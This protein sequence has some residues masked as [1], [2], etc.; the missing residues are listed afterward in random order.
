MLTRRLL[1]AGT[2]PSPVIMAMV[3]CAFPSICA[4]IVTTRRSRAGRSLST[5]T[6]L[7]RSSPTTKSAKLHKVVN[8]ALLKDP[9]LARLGSSPRSAYRAVTVGEQTYWCFTMTARLPGLG[10]VRPATSIGEA[11]RQ[12]AQALIEGEILYAHEQLQ[13]GSAS[14][15]SLRGCLPARAGSHMTA[16]PSFTKTQQSS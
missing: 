4:S 11:G 12:Q 5:N 9:A 2:I 10:K 14:K 1:S 7:T 15:R 6:F 16:C 3:P 8:P 13:R